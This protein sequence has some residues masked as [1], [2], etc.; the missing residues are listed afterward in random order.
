MPLYSIIII[1]IIIILKNIY[2]INKLIQS[3]LN[4]C[5]FLVAI[6]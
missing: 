1:I 4:M 6:K 5:G 2:V 3:Q